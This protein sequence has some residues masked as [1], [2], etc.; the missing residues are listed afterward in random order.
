MGVA[1]TT[2]TAAMNDIQESLLQLNA[3]LARIAANQ[4][5]MLVDLK[6]TTARPT[7]QPGRGSWRAK[8]RLSW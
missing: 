5:K 2:T 3:T 4:D 1:A 7:P 8:H 6:K